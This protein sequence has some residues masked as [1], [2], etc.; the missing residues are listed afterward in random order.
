MRR[1]DFYLILCGLVVLF[2]LSGGYYVIGWHQFQKAATH[3]EKLAP[4]IKSGY[5]P[6][7]IYSVGVNRQLAEIIKL[8]SVD[9]LFDFTNR[10]YTNDTPTELRTAKK[11]L[12]ENEKVF[13]KLKSRVSRT[14]LTNVSYSDRSFRNG[15]LP[16]YRLIELFRLKLIFSIKTGHSAEAVS[17]MNEAFELI[18]AV[19]FLNSWW[20]FDRNNRE[21]AVL[22]LQGYRWLLDTLPLNDKELQNFS[23]ELEKQK[24]IIF[25]SYIRTLVIETNRFAQE[26]TFFRQN[27]WWTV[28]VVSSFS[29]CPWYSKATVLDYSADML[30]K[31]KFA[32]ISGQSSPAHPRLKSC[33]GSCIAMRYLHIYHA[34]YENLLFVLDLLNRMNIATQVTHYSNRTGRRPLRLEDLIPAYLSRADLFAPTG[35]KYWIQYENP[36]NSEWYFIVNP[37]CRAAFLKSI[38]FKCLKNSFGIIS[39]DSPNHEKTGRYNIRALRDGRQPG[40]G[41]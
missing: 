4:V 39:N 2:L 5:E 29:W 30:E 31:L 40:A 27:L 28:P 22:L 6:G 15:T 10:L 19:D 17:T 9:M 26:Y 3:W 37:D 21:R 25:Q 34:Q 32:Y 23:A 14:K 36:S 13:Q 18:N 41:E 38:K 35:N 1:K 33:S 7:K 8:P 24:K 16:Y 20:G 12:A 11:M